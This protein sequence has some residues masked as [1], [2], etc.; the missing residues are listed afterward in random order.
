LASRLSERA[1]SPLL[2]QRQQCSIAADSLT[3]LQ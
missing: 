2:L 1:S 3:A